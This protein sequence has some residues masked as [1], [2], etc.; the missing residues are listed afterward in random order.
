MTIDNQPNKT[1][2]HYARRQ[3]DQLN[4]AKRKG[5]H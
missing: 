4:Q 5:R 3:E 1:T 2:E